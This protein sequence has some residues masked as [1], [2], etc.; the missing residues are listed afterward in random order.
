[1]PPVLAVVAPGQGSQRPGQL[2]PWL[3]LPGVIEQVGVLAEAAQVDLLAAGT[4]WPADRLVAT[5]VAQPLTVVTSLVAGRALLGGPAGI[6]TGIATAD[7]LAGHSVGEWTAAVL[8]GVLDEV[9]ALRLVGLRG[10]AMADCCRAGSTG[11]S[12]VLG[13]EPAEVLDRL[14][15]L[16]LVPANVNAPG[17]VVAGGP[18]DALAALAASPPTRAR[19]RPLAVAGAF[20]TAAMAPAVPVLAAA[21][22]MIVGQDPR[23][24]VLSNLDGQP[25]LDGG[26][27]LDRLVRQVAEPVRWDRCMEAMQRLGVTALVEL[28]PAGTLAALARR[29]LPG[30]RVVALD[31]PDRLDQARDVLAPALAEATR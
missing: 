26:Q 25:V 22:A 11:L 2:A 3:E 30:V 9:A 18:A 8:A 15:A 23:T 27:L 13:G 10:R 20:H 1:M 4:R 12:A 6:A 29:G 21:R 14:A 19:V 5:D 28:A 7:V 31:G 17:Q 24:T 16:A